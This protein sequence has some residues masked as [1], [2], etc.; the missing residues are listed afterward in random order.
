MTDGR[1]S[2]ASGKVPSAIHLTPEAID[3]GG[4]IAKIRDGDVIRLDA[5]NGGLE[6]LG[7]SAAEFDARAAAVD[8]VSQ[9]HILMGREL[10]RSVPGSTVGDSE[11]GAGVFGEPSL[12]VPE[13]SETEKVV[14]G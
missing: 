7:A 5:E 8:D 10:F 1:M 6:V 11:T 4:P 9:S 14:V 13:A 3:D 12:T 2:G